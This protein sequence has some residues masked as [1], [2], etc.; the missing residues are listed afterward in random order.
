ILDTIWHSL[1]SLYEM[2][3]HLHYPPSREDFERARR[4]MMFEN[5]LLLQLGLIQQKKRRKQEQGHALDIDTAVIDA[6]TKT[7]P[8]RFTGAQERAT[9]EILADVQTDQPM[10]RLLQGDV[11]SG[12]TVVAATIALIAHANGMQTAFM[13]PTE[14]LAEQHAVSFETLFAPLPDEARPTVALLTG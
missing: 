10:T 13:A 2:Y 9:R 4:R 1:P 7:L 11:G 8:F 5:L 3:D 6:F 14:L 12:K